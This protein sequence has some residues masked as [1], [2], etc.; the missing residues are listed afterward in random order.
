MNSRAIAHQT[1]SPSVANVLV[2]INFL[3]TGIVMTFLGP[4]L[5]ILA[6]R[7]GINDSLAGRLFL[8]QFVSSMLGM[9]CSAPAVKRYGY[10]ATFII[11]LVLMS[12]GTALLASAPYW[13]GAIAVAILGAGH[14]I[15]TP[16]GNL[17]T[18][19]VNPTR[20]AAALNVIN[21]IWGIGAMSPAFLLDAARDLNHPTWFLYGTSIALIAL[22]VSF[23]VLP[24]APNSNHG[25]REPSRP[26]T[27][28]SLSLPM[29]SLIVLFFFLYVGAETSFGQWVATY[30]HRLE[31]VGAQW[32]LMPSLFY[33]AMLLGRISAPVFLKFLPEVSVAIVGLAC[34]LLGGAALLKA[35][36]PELIVTGSLL[37]GIG[38]SSIFPISVSLFPRWFGD[39]ARAAS[40]MVFAGGNMGGAVLPWL[41][42]VISSRTD[43]LEVGFL[44]PESA[45]FIMLVFYIVQQVSGRRTQIDQFQSAAHL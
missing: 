6:A 7:W 3:L 19:E 32:T 18:A 38:L 24:F 16:A 9:F 23:F 4:M 37:T 33:G 22:L 10:R 17:R 39:S 21:A 41:V 27:A 30:A 28:A 29:L 26:Y 35:N 40:G 13:L 5:P 43:S 36:G 1:G 42:G 14:G 15:T 31:A 44:V 45:V 12:S 20:S 11:G 25:S 34:A 8:V 2:H